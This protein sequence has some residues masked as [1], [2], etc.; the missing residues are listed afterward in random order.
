M[1]EQLFEPLLQSP[2]EANTTSPTK[3]NA[4]S[5]SPV[6]LEVGFTEQVATGDSLP[7]PAELTGPTTKPVVGTCASIWWALG[8]L[9]IPITVPL[10]LLLLVAISPVYFSFYLCR[11]DDE[12]C[13]HDN[14]WDDYIR[15]SPGWLLFPLSFPLLIVA[16]VLSWPLKVTQNTVNFIIRGTFIS[17]IL[18]IDTS[19]WELF[20]DPILCLLGIPFWLLVGEWDQALE[21]TSQYDYPLTSCLFSWLPWP[22]GASYKIFVMAKNRSTNG[23]GRLASIEDREDDLEKKQCA[24]FEM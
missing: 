18:G 15:W 4:I 6:D 1:T 16:S 10:S 13:F 8:W 17:S 24:I 3:T 22:H 23:V 21:V 9:L 19:H 7:L 12:P 14:P 5:S 20:I 11:N 2:L